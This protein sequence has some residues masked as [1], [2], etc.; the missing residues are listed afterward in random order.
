MNHHPDLRDSYLRW[1]EA[2]ASAFD[3]PPEDRPNPWL[4]H[5]NAF[6]RRGD[7][8][9]LFE[10]AVDSYEK[11]TSPFLAYLE[12]PRAVIEMSDIYGKRIRRAVDEA[13]EALLDML[14]DLVGR[15]WAIGEA[16]T[17]TA[18]DLERHGWNPTTALPDEAD[19]I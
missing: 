14:D 7:L 9:R 8:L 12:A 11:L 15:L 4:K 1:Y 3:L 13:Q 17:V 10:E 5:V 19:Y 6:A 2:M 16:D 18:S